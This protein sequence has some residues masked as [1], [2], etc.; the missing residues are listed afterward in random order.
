MIA[1]HGGRTSLHT[2]NSLEPMTRGTHVK[3]QPTSTWRRPV[4][5]MGSGPANGLR[6]PA[7]VSGCPRRSIVLLTSILSLFSILVLMVTA[8]LCQASDWEYWSR[9]DFRVPLNKR[10]KLSIKPEIRLRDNM[11][12]FYYFKAYVGPTLK[13]TD[14]LDA[15]LYYV[16]I[17]K[18]V[19]DVWESED[20]ATLDGTLSFG[21]GDFKFAWRNRGEYGFDSERWVYRARIKGARP[22]RFCGRQVASL[23][24]HEL[25][26]DFDGGSSNERR[27]SIGLSAKLVD[28]IALE[29]S[30]IFRN[31]RQGGEWR[32]VNVLDTSL[33]FSL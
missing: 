1:L 33:Q 22:V 31:K 6:T 30:Y 13:I 10:T 28:R 14:H 23:L 7:R 20:L 21:L 18:Q 19:G 3:L 9:T 15:A 11:S 16:Y 5:R 17:R 2:I 25:F 8:E 29:A 26:Y 27:T 32:S 12:E 4:L 24:S